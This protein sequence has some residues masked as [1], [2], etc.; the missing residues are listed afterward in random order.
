MVD[1]F[2]DGVVLVDDHGTITLANMRLD[3]MFGYQH[4]ELLG[5]PV[6]FLIPSDL[7]DGRRS[8]LA[9]YHRAPRTR[10]MGDGVALVGLRK[11]GTIFPGQVGLSPVPTAAGQSTLA[12]IR[13]VTETRRLQDRLHE[14]SILHDRERIADD[15]RDRVIQRIFAAG[16]TLEGA[17]AMT[18]Q[19]EVRR[20]VTSSIDELD[21]AIRILRDTI[22]SLDDRLEGHSFRAGITALCGE[23]SPT[24]EINFTGPV[25]GALH[26]ADSTQL[27]EILRDALAL[28][29]Q[30]AI[31]ARISITADSDSH[32]TIIDAAPLSLANGTGGTGHWFPALR[33]QADRSGIRL[34][35]DPSPYGTRLSWRIRATPPHN[36]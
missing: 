21:Q 12:V 10:P 27:L 2:Q 20:R 5:H 23:L 15:L 33:D 18:T 11:D 6:E 25:D 4:D 22:F 7:Q 35:I 1:A 30:H 13:E 31:P 17:A 16:L 19:P 34:D 32:R 26:P 36:S 24:P 29:S 14:P 8:L 3:A 9:D 28:I